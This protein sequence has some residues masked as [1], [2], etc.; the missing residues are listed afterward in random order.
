[1]IISVDTLC[2]FAPK[3]NQKQG[4]S[5]TGQYFP[6]FNNNSRAIIMVKQLRNLTKPSLEAT[7]M[8]RTCK[9]HPFQKSNT[10]PPNLIT[11]DISTSYVWTTLRGSIKDS[12]LSSGTSLL[13]GIKTG[14]CLIRP[15]VFG[16]SLMR[17]SR[18]FQKLAWP[19]RAL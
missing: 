12:L 18:G 3:G 10:E 17:G 4:K 16:S 15:F 7:F 13:N 5:N 19:A 9:S 1:M 6:N 2:G 11:V 8:N 14:W